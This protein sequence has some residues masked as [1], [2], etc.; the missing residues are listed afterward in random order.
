[1]PL[2]KA[3]A[4][5]PTDADYL[6]GTAHA[7]LSAEIPVGATPGGELGGTWSSPTVDPTHADV[8]VGAAMPGGPATNDRCYRTDLGMEFYYD[9]T[10][11][12]SSTLLTASSGVFDAF[13]PYAATT[14]TERIGSTIGLAAGNSDVWLE[15]SITSFFI[16]GGTALGASHK[17]VITGTKNPGAAALATTIATI[18]SG[19]SSV[20]R[21]EIVAHNALLTAGTYFNVDLTHTKTGTPGTFRGQVTFTYRIVST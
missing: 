8:T 21:Q 19:A 11:W 7:G 20:W 13:Q 6:V 5:A 1:M 2:Y 10:R 3:A 18:A 9:G 14:T 12:L 17:W 16:S 4:G 15:D